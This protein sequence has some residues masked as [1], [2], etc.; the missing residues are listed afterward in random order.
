MSV[1]VGRAAVRNPLGGGLHRVPCKVGV[2]GGR[3]DPTVAEELSDHRQA[4]AEG[5]SPGGKAVPKVAV[6]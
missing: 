3:L 1:H 4:F 6:E 5:E 2:A